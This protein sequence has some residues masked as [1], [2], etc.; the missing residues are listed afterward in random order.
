M[1]HQ[2]QTKDNSPWKE[3]R[4]MQEALLCGAAEMLRDKGAC[5]T[6]ALKRTFFMLELLT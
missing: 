2:E 3:R 4:V 1:E 5:E 6:G